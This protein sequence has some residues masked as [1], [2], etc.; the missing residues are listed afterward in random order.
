MN[1]NAD[2]FSKYLSE[3]FPPSFIDVFT[4]SETGGCADG[5]ACQSPSQGLAVTASRDEDAN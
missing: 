3:S 4:V 5:A 1:L 2:L